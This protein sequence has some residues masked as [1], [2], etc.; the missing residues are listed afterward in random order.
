MV[1]SVELESVEIE[2]LSDRVVGQFT[3]ESSGQVEVEGDARCGRDRARG[4]P[5]VLRHH[6]GADRRGPAQVYDAS[7]TRLVTDWVRL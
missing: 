3:P 5:R 6:P 4:R 2:V 1:F 7:S